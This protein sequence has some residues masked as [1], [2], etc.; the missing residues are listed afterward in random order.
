MEKVDDNRLINYNKALKDKESGLIA[1]VKKV[2]LYVNWQEPGEGGQIE[3]F[4]EDFPKAM[5]FLKDMVKFLSKENYASQ[6]HYPSLSYDFVITNNNG[7]TMGTFDS[8][9]DSYD[10]QRM[11]F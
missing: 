11:R 10:A 7:T 4:G 1:D 5:E 2:G 8:L 3:F 6:E 9:I